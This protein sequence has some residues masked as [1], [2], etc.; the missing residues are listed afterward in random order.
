MAKLKAKGSIILEILIVILIVALLF[1]L[2]Y[3]K[4][5]WEEEEN[6]TKLCRNNMDRILKAELVYQKFQNSYTDSLAGLISFFKDDTTKLVIRD[7]FHA[8]TAL[9]EELV[10]FLTSKNKPA[11]QLINNIMADT[12]MYSIMESVNYDSNLARVILNRLE[13]TALADSVKAKRMSDSSD[14]YIFK[15]L[16]Q[17]LNALDIYS[18]IRD[19]DSLKLVF[20][21]MMPD[22][23]VGTLLD[24]LYMAD[25]SWAMKIDSAVFNTVEGFAKCPTVKRDY[26]ISVIDTAVIKYVNIECPLDSTDIEENRKNFIRYFFGHQ[27]LQNHGKITETGDKSWGR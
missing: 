6:N 11:D 18:P 20:S 22:V 3:P 15:E 4:K 5:V 19:D 21:R 9:A 26:I 10:S 1:T 13:T 27:R 23:S 2:L 7:Y 25:S 24:T 12:L 8:D 16:R 14:V 17:E